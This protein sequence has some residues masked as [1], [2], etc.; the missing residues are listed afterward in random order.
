MGNTAGTA[1]KVLGY[2]VIDFLD[3]DGFEANLDEQ[4]RDGSEVSMLFRISNWM[5]CAG[6]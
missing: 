6:R 2:K 5:C 3:I 4:K 1:S